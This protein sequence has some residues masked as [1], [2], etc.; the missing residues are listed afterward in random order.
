MLKVIG[1]TRVQAT[2]ILNDLLVPRVKRITQVGAILSEKQGKGHDYSKVK[3]RINK[4][5]SEIAFGGDLRDDGHLV[6][7]S[8]YLAIAG[9][10]AWLEQLPE[11]E[12]SA[13]WFISYAP[14]A[15]RNDKDRLEQ[16]GMKGVSRQDPDDP[17]V[18]TFRTWDQQIA[19]YERAIKKS[20]EDAELSPGSG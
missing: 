16:L 6:T 5:N 11:K 1:I 20:K 13:V 15:I 12:D 2:T 3:I 7:M 19:A 4:H 14:W 8:S 18:F 17:H 10:L 9:H